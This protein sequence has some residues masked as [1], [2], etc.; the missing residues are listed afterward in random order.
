[1]RW[2][3]SSVPPWTKWSWHGVPDRSAVAHSLTMSVKPMSFP[4][5]PIVTSWVPASRRSNCRGRGHEEVRSPDRGARAPGSSTAALAEPE[6]ARALGPGVPA[7]PG[8]DAL[9]HNDLLLARG[10]VGAGRVRTAAEAEPCRREE[11][12]PSEE[13]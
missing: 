7:L 1:M 11:L 10:Q 3:I 12:K 13:A 8:E 6:L 2:L 9:G 4:P 5:M